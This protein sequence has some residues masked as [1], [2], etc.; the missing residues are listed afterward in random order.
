MAI[1][2][3]VYAGNTLIDLTGDTVTSPAHI[4]SG[5]I[6]HLANG[7]KVTGTGSGSASQSIYTGTS[8]PAAS[9]GANGDIYIHANAGG[10]LEAY[11]ASFEA[12]QMNS[13]SAASNCIGKSA[14]DGTSTSN[15]YSSGNNTV[16]VVEYSFDLSSIPADAVITDVSCQVKAHEENASRS[17]MTLQLYAGNTAKGSQTTVSGT[18]NKIYDLDCGSWTRSEVENLVLHSRYGYYGGLVAG[19]T[20]TITYEMGKDEYDVSLIGSA[21]EWRISGSGIYQKSGGTWTQKPSVTLSNVIE[22]K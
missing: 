9:L 15:M 18:S 10:S 8:S 19:A 6:G 22:R 4:M 13:T 2:K 14:E 21:S 17:T 1:N 3:V 12:S 11:P 5:Y 7:E 16:G 20:L